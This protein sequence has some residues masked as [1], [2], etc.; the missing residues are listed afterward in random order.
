MKTLSIIG[1]VWAVLCFI[2]LVGFNTP[3][4]YEAAIGWGMFAAIYLLAISIVYLVKV[5]RK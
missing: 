3:A 4:D 1:I 2:C 5:D